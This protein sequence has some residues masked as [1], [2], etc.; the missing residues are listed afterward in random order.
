LER[1]VLAWDRYKK[2]LTG[3]DRTGLLHMRLDFRAISQKQQSTEHMSELG[4]IILT[5]NVSGSKLKN[6]ITTLHLL[7]NWI[8]NNS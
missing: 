8:S 3:V 2:S 6:G 4:H 7:D 5:H 1:K